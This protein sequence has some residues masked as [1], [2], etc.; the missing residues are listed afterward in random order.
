MT[1]AWIA[2][3]VAVAV[4]EFAVFIDCGTLAIGRTDDVRPLAGGDGPLKVAPY[5]LA[6]GRIEYIKLMRFG[7]GGL[8]VGCLLY[9]RSLGSPLPSQCT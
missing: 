3:R 4:F 2:S 7:L 1:R 5:A 8:S 6:A 9:I